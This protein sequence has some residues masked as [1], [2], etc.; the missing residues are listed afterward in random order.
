MT[1]SSNFL[2]GHITKSDQGI[3]CF[4][5]DED[6][7]GKSLLSNGTW[8]SKELSCLKKIVHDDDNILIL[9]AHIGTLAIPISV[10]CNHVYAIEANP[11]IYKFLKANI[12]LNDRNNIDPYMIAASD[13]AGTIDF[14]STS[15][16]TGGS[17]IYPI[18]PHPHYLQDIKNI[19]KVQKISIDELLPEI[20]AR[21][22]FIDIEGSE[23]F[24]LRGMK[25]CL[26]KSEILFI[27]YIPYHLEFVAGITPE[28][29]SNELE[30]YYNFL[31]VPGLNT[32]FD[33]NKFKDILR[34]MYEEKHSEDQ[35]IFAKEIHQLKSL[36]NFYHAI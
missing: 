32:Y 14:I 6:G 31:Y 9:G 21:I 23:I 19:Y 22:I 33:R 2:F 34:H 7:I 16:N 25:N 20:E 26:R 18:L 28:E 1:D 10:D 11:D 15:G 12:F 4:P 24:A 27:E 8:G 5:K 29:F 17:K 30:K 13:T 35:I 3:F 36:Q